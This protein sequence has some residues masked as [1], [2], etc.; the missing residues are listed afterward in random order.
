MAVLTNNSSTQEAKAGD[1]RI[2]RLDWVT[3][4]DPVWGKRVQIERTNY[5]Q[6]NILLTI[7]K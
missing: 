5:I 1:S 6:M 2:S 3:Q 7:Y 4:E